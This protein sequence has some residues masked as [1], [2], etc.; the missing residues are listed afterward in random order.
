V[1][2]RASHPWIRSGRAKLLALMA[3]FPE[4]LCHALVEFLFPQPAL[5]R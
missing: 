1:A 3:G 5:C 4:D 2:G